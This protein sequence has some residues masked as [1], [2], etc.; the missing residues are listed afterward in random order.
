MC[1]VSKKYAQSR[2]RAFQYAFFE[3]LVTLPAILFD[4]K[5]LVWRVF[6]VLTQGSRKCMCDSADPRGLNY[7]CGVCNIALSALWTY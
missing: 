2:S 5:H 6:V 3:K 4:L 1:S 7:D